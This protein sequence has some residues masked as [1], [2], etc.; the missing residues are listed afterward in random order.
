MTI[1]FGRKHFLKEKK[2]PPQTSCIFS[3]EKSVRWSRSLES[4]RKMPYRKRPDS[5]IWN[6]ISK[7]LSLMEF[8]RHFSSTSQIREKILLPTTLNTL[9]ITWAGDKRRFRMLPVGLLC[10]L[11][12]FCNC[13]VS[14]LTIS[15]YKKYYF[16]E[17]NRIF[18][19]EFSHITFFS[20]LFYFENSLVK[21]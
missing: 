6:I 2:N 3:E 16:Q 18:V 8:T 9:D 4:W 1:F 19:T 10:L 15:I 20:K 14:V 21:W 13:R 17:N 12:R 5:V 7:A 11:I